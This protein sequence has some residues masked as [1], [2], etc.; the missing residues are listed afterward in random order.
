MD[1]HLWKSNAVF[2][3]LL[4]IGLTS[5]LLSSA[6]ISCSLPGAN[7]AQALGQLSGGPAP[8]HGLAR[9]QVSRSLVPAKTAFN[10]F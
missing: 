10:H 2:T 8:P 6:P 5:V 3:S 7:L 4:P 9:K 1:G